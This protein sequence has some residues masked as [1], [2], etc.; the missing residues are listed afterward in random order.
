VQYH[1]VRLPNG[2]R[3]AN[4]TRLTPALRHL[5]NSVDV[6]VPIAQAFENA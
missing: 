6:E 1:Q 3:L 4:L 2:Q 5:F